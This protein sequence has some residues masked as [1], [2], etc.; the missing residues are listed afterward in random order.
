[1]QTYADSI[2]YN[3]AKYFYKKSDIQLS[4]SS[5]KNTTI[6]DG[7]SFLK[8]RTGEKSC[9]LE[10]KKSDNIIVCEH[11]ESP[12][13]C[14]CNIWHWYI[15]LNTNNE[16]IES[17]NIKLSLDGLDLTKNIPNSQIENFQLSDYKNRKIATLAL[18]KKHPIGS[19]TEHL[20]ETL[21]NSNAKIQKKINKGEESIHYLYRRRQIN[22]LNGWHITV[23]SSKSRI[24][25]ITISRDELTI[26]KGNL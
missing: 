21:K 19:Q 10:I 2:T 11:R 14:K 20:L 24:Q 7:L 23:K 9:Y 12:D 5:L 18:L 22:D 17:F 4:L 8:N 1:M 16:L 15:I 25:N 6:K 3:K 13:N 26:K